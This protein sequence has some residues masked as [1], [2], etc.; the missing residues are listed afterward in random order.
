MVGCRLAFISGTAVWTELNT[1][2]TL[3]LFKEHML[4]EDAVPKYAARIH[5]PDERALLEL[6]RLSD[7]VIREL[8]HIEE[9]ARQ[10]LFFRRVRIQPVLQVYWH[11]IFISHSL[12]RVLR[13][14]VLDPA[15]C[16]RAAPRSRATTVCMRAFTMPPAGP[17]SLVVRHCCG[18][19]G[20]CVI[21]QA[22]SKSAVARGVT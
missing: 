7:E 15:G 19:C 16:L 2:V 14:F 6:L 12:R 4:V 8:L 17:S 3:R 11:N 13:F 1:F 21:P 18:G 9:F 20:R 22:F 5:C 10:K